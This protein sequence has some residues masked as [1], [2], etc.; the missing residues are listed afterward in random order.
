MIIL[1]NDEVQLPKLADLAP[2]YSPP[3]NRSSTP[4]NSLP[5]YDE[6]ELEIWKA[7][8]KEQDRVSWRR[9][10]F[11][12]RCWRITLITLVVYCIVTT[13]IGVPLILRF[14]RDRD[15]DSSYTH[16]SSPPGPWNT[17]QAVSLIS[18]A[19]SAVSSQP[20][21]DTSRDCDLWKS[22]DVMNKST[23][24]YM[25]MLH[26]STP[27]NYTGVFVGSN[28]TFRAGDNLSKAVSGSLF[29]D[30]NNDPSVETLEFDLTMTHSE[31]DLR[32]KTHICV[33]DVD[34]STGV[35]IYIPNTLRPQDRLVFNATLLLPQPKSDLLSEFATMLPLFR[36]QFGDLASVFE[37]DSVVL[38]GPM[39][40]VNVQSLKSSTV[41]IMS[42]P[43]E[44]RGSFDV[45]D[46]IVL[47][48]MSAPIDVNIILA[49]SAR[50]LLVSP[51]TSV[52]RLNT[53]NSPLHANIT[54]GI[55]PS[56]SGDNTKLTNNQVAQQSWVITANTFNAPLNL[57][58][59]QLGSTPSRPLNV[60]VQA[61]NNLGDTRIV[62]DEYFQGDFQ[63]Q[64]MYA[65]A[66]V[67]DAGV[68]SDSPFAQMSPSS[69]MDPVGRTVAYDDISD[70]TVT[71]W[72]GVGPRTFDN[73]ACLSVLSVLNP[74]VV[75]FG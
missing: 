13:A 39:S 17:G 37:F 64:T 6:S 75:E 33:A 16:Y 61:G 1:D 57:S 40:P 59:N 8:A 9:P 25:S 7:K 35:Y 41:A 52:A 51:P 34:R 22:T 23:N 27:L 56:S 74:V 20:P 10:Y 63:V 70:G 5:D 3:V 48:T 15:D 30:I 2:V 54:V 58:V 73:Q 68:D 4:T 28:G 12:R 32:S 47:E 65:S 31:E 19:Q 43:G 29:V 36:Q 46:S 55:K 44:I 45:Y 67:R 21:F 49:S 14:V 11:T 62:A 69:V 72:L 26:I 18:A 42:S 50:R 60:V 24:F 53:G 66:V 71:G 38:G